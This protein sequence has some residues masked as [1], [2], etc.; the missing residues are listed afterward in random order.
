MKI[1]LGTKEHM[2]QLFDESGRVSAVTAIKALPGAVT[3]V[4]T[5]ERDG[6]VAVQVGAGEKNPN[7]LSKPLKGHF[8]DLG[9]F[10]YVREFRVRGSEAP[11]KR[12]D[13]VEL[14]QFTEGDVVA[15]TG[16]SKGKG[17]QGVVKRHG[18]AGGQRTHGQKHSEREPGSIGQTGIQRVLK[19]T[20]MAGRMGADTVTERN[21]KVV[22]VDTEAGILYLKGAV[23]GRRGTLIKVV[24]Q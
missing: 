12:G 2:T 19:G 15:V 11:F 21:V 16:T 23:P 17:F 24:T 5:T 9:N 13:A 1:I 14:A 20:R 22:K 18:F 6:Y 8:G 4:R 3:D 10:R 7:R